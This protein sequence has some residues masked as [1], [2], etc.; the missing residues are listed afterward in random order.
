MLWANS[1]VHA[2]PCT[3]NPSDYMIIAEEEHGFGAKACA[4]SLF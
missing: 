2:V 4:T 3:S 1:I